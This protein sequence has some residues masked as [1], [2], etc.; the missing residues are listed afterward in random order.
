MRVEME[1]SGHAPI[2]QPP[3]TKRMSSP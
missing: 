2:V 1:V 3:T